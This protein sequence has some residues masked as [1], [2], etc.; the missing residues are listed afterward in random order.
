[1]RRWWQRSSCIPCPV[2][3]PVAAS[4]SLSLSR[5]TTAPVWG[6]K[7]LFRGVSVRREHPRLG[8]GCWGLEPWLGD[9]GGG[10]SEI[11]GLGKAKLPPAPI[12]SAG[13]SCPSS[14][15][16]CWRAGICHA[17]FSSV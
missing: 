16:S 7:L 5:G 6:D 2:T 1:M 10:R 15:K 14:R 13:G 3:A 11:R 12:T 9:R 17:A 4:W 8:K